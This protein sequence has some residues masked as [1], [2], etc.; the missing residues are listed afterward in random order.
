[1]YSEFMKSYELKLVLPKRTTIYMHFPSV[2]IKAVSSYTN[3]VKYIYK[4]WDRRK[5]IVV[6]ISF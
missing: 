5:L 3:T 1:M 2:A 6:L 4:Y